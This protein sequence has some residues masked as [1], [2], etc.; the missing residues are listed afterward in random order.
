MKLGTSLNTCNQ[1]SIDTVAPT[2]TSESK[3]VITT[4]T[5][6]NN[7]VSFLWNRRHDVDWFL[8]RTTYYKHRVIVSFTNRW[9]TDR[10]NMHDKNRH[11]LCVSQDNAFNRSISEMDYFNTFSVQSRP[12]PLDK[13]SRWQQFHSNIKETIRSLQL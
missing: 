13:N 2:F 8:N 7:I 12:V 1:N 3:K 11:T 5:T 9:T 4:S 10:R 6:E